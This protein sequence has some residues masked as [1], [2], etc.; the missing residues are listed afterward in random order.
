MLD[1]ND[2]DNDPKE[3]QNHNED[4]PTINAPE[5]VFPQELLQTRMLFKTK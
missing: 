5:D 4:E 3:T 2:N 1:D